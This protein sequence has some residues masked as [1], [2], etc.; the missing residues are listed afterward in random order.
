ML[1]GYLEFGSHSA[2]HHTLK[3][4]ANSW[5][6]VY[7]IYIKRQC[8]DFA[9]WKTATNQKTKEKKN[10]NKMNKTDPWCF[11]YTSD[12]SRP[13]D[14][15]RIGVRFAHIIA[16]DLNSVS[17]WVFHLFKL[18]A[19]IHSFYLSIS[20]CVVLIFCFDREFL[21]FFL[22][23]LLLLYVLMLLVSLVRVF[24]YC[25]VYFFS[26]IVHVLSPLVFF[27]WSSKVWH[28]FRFQN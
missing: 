6:Y 8:N 20:F 15:E 10:R 11:C 16:L 28:K 17:F 26:P 5:A 19:S 1:N 4:A 22:L 23:L 25:F 24:G 3:W 7:L 27:V 18:I 9:K 13:R 14:D 21:F 2:T 12:I